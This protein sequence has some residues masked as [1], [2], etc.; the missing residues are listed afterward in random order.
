MQHL[1]FLSR[2]KLFCVLDFDPN[3]AAQGGLCH[4]YRESRV[5]NMHTPS[6]YQELPDSVI[7]NLNLYKQTSWVFCNGRHDLDSNSHRQLDYRDWLRKSC[8]EVEH[9]V[10]FICNP[11]V[12]LRGRRLIIFL[13]LSPVDTE[14]DPVFDTYKCFIKHI[15][16]ES[17]IT[18]C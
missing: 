10:S 1:Q 15:E 16:E 6:Q 17:M 14:K 12:L 11:E 5:A 8:R 7:K 4:F 3:S 18:I 9:L 13:L 2:L